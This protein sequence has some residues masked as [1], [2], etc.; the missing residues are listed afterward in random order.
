MNRY[1]KYLQEKSEKYN[2]SYNAF[3][4]GISCHTIQELIN[5]CSSKEELWDI[6]DRNLD[7]TNTGKTDELLLYY[8]GE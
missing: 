8:Y 2:K 6:I 3:N 7:L 1:D 5:E 4:S